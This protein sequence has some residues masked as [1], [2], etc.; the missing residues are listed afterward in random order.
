MKRFKL[1]LLI[2][3]PF[4]A[5]GCIAT[6]DDMGILKTQIAA[7][8]KTLQQ[9]Q[10]NQASLDVSMG[11]LSTQLTQSSDNLK[12]FDYKLDELSV[13]IDN[14][15]SVV[16]SKEAAPMLPSE[17]YDGAKKQFESSRYEEAAKGFALYLKAAPDGQNAPDAYLMQAQ[18]Y[19][20]LKKYEEAALSSAVLL[21]KFPKS[22]L[23]AAARLVYAQ[24]IL[25]L[26]KKDEAKTYLKSIEQD[27]KDSKEA[28][29]AQKLLKEIK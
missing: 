25:P 28:S 27:F 4:F 18:S 24:S 22:K 11:E 7:L 23:T 14:I 21:D 3:S 15:A 5:F 29:E 8:N 12:N 2:L 10:A 26:D 16:G 6:Q 13:K 17:L 9:L 19:F 20:E 1:F